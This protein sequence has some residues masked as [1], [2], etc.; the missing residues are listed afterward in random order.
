MSNNVKFLIKI[1][2]VVVLSL[3]ILGVAS[4]FYTNGMTYKG[5][6]SGI[7]KYD[8]IPENIEYANFGPSYGMNCFNYE[9]IEKLGKTG[10]NFSLTMQ[11][12]YHDYAIYKTYEDNFSDGAVVAIPLSYFSFCS[13][14]EAPSGNRY[15]KLLPKKYIKDYTLENDVSARLVPAYGKGDAIIRDLVSDT[16]NSIMKKSV[17]TK[18]KESD[19]QVSKEVAE[20]SKDSQVRV[21]TIETGNLKAYGN[22][23]KLNEEILIS[24]INEMKEKNLRPV[25]LLTPYWYEYANGFDEELLKVSYTDPVSRVIERTGIDYINFCSEEYSEFT[26]NPEYFSNCDH[27]SKVGSKEFMKLYISYLKEKGWI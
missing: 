3:A 17:T 11:D 23:I 12:L 13:N 9:S 21:L 20:L 18:V 7:E 26:H 5:A 19:V 1:L 6:Y 14:T 8:S 25:L 4:L 2:A 27:I 10:F 22:Q 16:L 24:W 15:Y